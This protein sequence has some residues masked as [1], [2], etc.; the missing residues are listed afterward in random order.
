[1]FKNRNSVL[2]LGVLVGSLVIV[3]CV[4]V[5]GARTSATGT[6]DGPPSLDQTASVSVSE[7]DLNQADSARPDEEWGIEPLGVMLSAAGHILDFRYRVTDPEKA[8]AFMERGIKPYL[9]NQETGAK[10]FVPRPPKVGPMRQ[11]S[12]QPSTDRTYF[13]FF[14]NPGRFIKPGDKVTVAVG[15]CRI[16]DLVV[17]GPRAEGPEIEG[18]RGI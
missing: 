8:L 3:V 5:R 17:V 10:A 11:T 16:E 4:S 1:M 12:R 15:E 2:L 14:A 7:N 18:E 6:P 13:I 9:V